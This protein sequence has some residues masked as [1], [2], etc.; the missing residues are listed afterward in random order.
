M[1]YNHTPHGVKKLNRSL[2]LGMITAGAWFLFEP[3]IGVLDLLPDAAGYLFIFLGLYRMADLDD[4]LAEARKGAR[5]LALLGLARLVAM[6]LSFGVVSP[7]EQPVFMLLTLFSLAVLDCL[8]LV[9]MWRNFCGGLLYLGSRHDATVMFD[10]RGLGKRPRIYNMVERY[11]TISTVFF[12]L[13]E[14]L[15]VLPELTVLSHEKGGAE[16]GQGTHYYD[17]VGFF[18]VVGIAISLVLGIIWLILTIR[19]IRR[20]KG[21]TPFFARLTEKYRAEILPRHDL[22]ARRAVGS[23]MVCLI[24]A[25]VLSMDIYLDG[26]NL[27]PDFLSAILLLLSVLFLQKYAGKNRLAQVLTISYGIINV[28]L[29]VMQ[30]TYF[31]MNDM[32]EVFGEIHGHATFYSPDMQQRWVVTMLLQCVGSAL[33]IGA[34]GSILKSIFGMIRRYTGLHAYREG[35]A[36]VAE[37]NEAIHKLLRKKLTVVFVFSVLVA[38]STLFEWGL[39]PWLAEA[40]IHSIL[41]ISGMQTTSPLYTFAITGYQILTEGYWF[42][43]LCIGAALVGVTISATGE[44]ADQMEYSSMMK[45]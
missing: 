24:V 25:A 30:F 19:T 33:F 4:R 16:L 15:A 14:A 21:D 45:D 20:L 2:G 27:V 28:V 23:A 17:F 42:I 38:L 31:G 43:D 18:R 9:P 7:T 32:G 6:F 37:R 5:N 44:I 13:H 34:M 3:Y 12:I 8:V 35:S 22:F 29:W 26:I 10:R 11:T 41:G 40:D 1:N 36:Y 39:A